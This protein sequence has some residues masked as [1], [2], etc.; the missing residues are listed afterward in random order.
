[1]NGRDAY[2]WRRQCGEKCADAGS[3]QETRKD[4]RA[5]VAA[6]ERRSLLRRK[7]PAGWRK[8]LAS[9]AAFLAAL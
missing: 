3:P 2:V 5:D 6:V 9:A 1:M 4:P 8:R 7:D